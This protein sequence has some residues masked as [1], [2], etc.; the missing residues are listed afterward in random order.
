MAIIIAC[1]ENKKYFWL[2]RFGALPTYVKV[3]KRMAKDHFRIFIL[4]NIPIEANSFGKGEMRLEDGSLRYQAARRTAIFSQN[5]FRFLT[6]VHI[7]AS[8]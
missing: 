7:P 4:V 6:Y 1:G 2:L 8:P 3:F 5:R